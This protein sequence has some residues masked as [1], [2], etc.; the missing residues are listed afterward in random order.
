MRSLKKQRGFISALMG[1]ALV[2]G[3]A[4]L[5]GGNRANKANSAQAQRQM[6]FQ[7]RMSSTA[8]EREVAD[9][10]K[11]G[12]NPILSAGGGGASSPGGAMANQQDIA[13]PAAT[14]ALNVLRTRAEI[15]NIQAQTKLTN[16]KSG[17]IRP[18][19]TIGNTAGDFMG[20]LKKGGANAA[21][22]LQR[23]IDQYYRNKSEVTQPNRKK[24]GPLIIR[25]PR[26]PQWSKTK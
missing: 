19:E 11:A 1:S 18:A 8:H 9:L 4:S 14:T 6:D 22:Q 25:I 5:I 15:G 2:G 26:P 7:E 13:T 3:A 24:K 10:R 23:A 20:Y 21:K 12:L 16:A 17:S